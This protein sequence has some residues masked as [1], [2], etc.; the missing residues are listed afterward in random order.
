MFII[1]RLRISLPILEF[2]RGCPRVDSLRR[3]CRSV[4]EV[5][6]FPAEDESADCDP[7]R[8]QSTRAT[9][10]CV[11]AEIRTNAVWG[12]PQMT[13]GGRLSSILR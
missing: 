7:A 6:R 10:R 11:P 2:R 1:F 5:S 12:C 13:P 9:I 8:A 3:P 4:H